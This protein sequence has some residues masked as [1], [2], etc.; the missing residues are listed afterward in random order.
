MS[1]PYRYWTPVIT[2]KS[3]PEK[4]TSNNSFRGGFASQQDRIKH[5]VEKMFTVNVGRHGHD[6]EGRKAGGRSSQASR[7]EEAW[8]PKARAAVKFFE[9]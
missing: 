1:N 3:T 6:H 5:A 2:E 9:A 4:K 8:Y 7:L